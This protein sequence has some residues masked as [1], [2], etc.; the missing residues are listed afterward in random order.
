MKKNIFVML[1]VI[2]TGSLVYQPFLGAQETEEEIVSDEVANDQEEQ[3]DD[4][5]GPS[6]D[7]LNQPEQPRKEKWSRARIL[8]VRLGVATAL[9]IQNF[10]EWLNSTW[11][12]LVSWVKC[13]ERKA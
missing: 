1:C 9:G 13:E 12:Y 10:Y 11:T 2:L 7:L 6:D 5:F 3:F 4:F 8:M